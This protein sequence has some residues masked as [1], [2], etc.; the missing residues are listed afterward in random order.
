[1]SGVLKL[2]TFDV[3]NTI[4]KV[5]RSPG[6][7]YALVARQNGVNITGER[8]DSVYRE[9]WKAK[10]SEHPTYGLNHGITSKEWWEDFVHRVFIK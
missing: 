4:L 7:Q 8:I 6:Y 10:K 5:H 2:V 3:V 1:M 9:V